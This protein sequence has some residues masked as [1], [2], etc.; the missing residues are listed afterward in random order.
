MKKRIVICGAAWIAAAFF[1]G[2]TLLRFA[3]GVPTAEAAGLAPLCVAL[4]EAAPDT[5]AAA[6]A[7]QCVNVNTD[8]TQRLIDLPGIGPV[9]ADRIVA[10]RRAHGAYRTPE[11]LDAV[12][13]IGPAKLAKIRDGICF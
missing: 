7:A 9:L 4:A 2:G 6:G 10:Y 11:D 3:G 13:G 12:R 8:G 1:F 5:N